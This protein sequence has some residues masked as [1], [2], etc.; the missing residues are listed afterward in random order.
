MSEMPQQKRRAN[1]RRK[2]KKKT[3][4]TERTARDPLRTNDPNEDD[5]S[6]ISREVTRL[7]V[8]EAGF[9]TLLEEIHQADIQ[10]GNEPAL[11]AQTVLRFFQI[12]LEFA[13]EAEA[14]IVE[15][16]KLYVRRKKSEPEQAY[17]K[18]ALEIVKSLNIQFNTSAAKQAEAL[19]AALTQDDAVY[20]IPPRALLTEPFEGEQIIETLQETEQ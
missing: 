4:Q 12:S 10:Q 1:A 20:D 7:S 13:R 18:E 11:D 8:Y 17:Y 14:L 16:R 19:K 9:R 3:R 6:R 2:P 5:V 15:L